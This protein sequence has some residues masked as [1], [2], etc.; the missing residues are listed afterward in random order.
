MTW[1]PRDSYEDPRYH[2]DHDVD[3]DVLLHH[4]SSRRW[5]TA[6]I[7]ATVAAIVVCVGW[8]AI[9]HSGAHEHASVVT[10]VSHRSVEPVPDKALTQLPAAP[11]QSLTLS[12]PTP[13]VAATEPSLRVNAPVRPIAKPATKLVPIKPRNAFAAMAPSHGVQSGPATPLHGASVALS[14]SWLATTY[15]GTPYVW[16]GGTPSDGFDCSGLVVFVY[17]VLGVELPRTTWAIWELG[18]R[19][20]RAH[21]RPGDL[22]FFNARDHM[23]IYVGSGNVVHAPHTGDRVKIT[24]LDKMGSYDGAVR[25]PE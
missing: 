16:A 11:V 23:G 7:T 19:I 21:L 14:A 18:S 10:P 4:A 9:H 12:S 22:V 6:V 15:I 25:L 13:A 1:P 24:P 8:L 2:L 5:M 17:G 20:E 3:V